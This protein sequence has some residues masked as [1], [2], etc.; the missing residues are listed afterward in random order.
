MLNSEQ[1]S[2]RASKPLLMS[3]L[4][5]EGGAQWGRVQ[6]REH[7]MEDDCSLAA[8][9]LPALAILGWGHRC[10]LLLWIPFPVVYRIPTDLTNRVL[11]CE[12]QLC[13]QRPV[14]AY[15]F[16]CCVLPLVLSVM[17]PCH[18][19]SHHTHTMALDC[20]SAILSPG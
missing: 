18:L 14:V 7:G 2:K 3:V 16:P 12:A 1:D 4:H 8:G 15:E 17:F 6:V 13:V 11:A 10:L 5:H 9:T 19:C 20:L